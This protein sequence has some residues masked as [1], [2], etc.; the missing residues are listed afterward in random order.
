MKQG[1]RIIGAG[2]LGL[3]APQTGELREKIALHACLQNHRDGHTANP[4]EVWRSDL[5]QHLA[6]AYACEITAAAIGILTANLVSEE[7]KKQIISS[8]VFS[9]SWDS[10]CNF[11]DSPSLEDEDEVIGRIFNG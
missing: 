11:A 7:K 8:T 6:T 2:R 10:C 4:W 3:K 9:T 1:S 5:K